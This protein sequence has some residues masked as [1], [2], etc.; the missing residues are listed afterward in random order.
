MSRDGAFWAIFRTANDRNMLRD[1]AALFPLDIYRVVS[2]IAVAGELDHDSDAL[3]AL[4]VASEKLATKYSTDPKRTELAGRLYEQALRLRERTPNDPRPLRVID[5]T[6]EVQTSGEPTGDQRAQL[7]RSINNLADE[8]HREIRQNTSTKKSGTYDVKA[9]YKRAQMLGAGSDDQQ[10][11]EQVAHADL[12][13]AD[14][15]IREKLSEAA[16]KYLKHEL[17]LE[18][19]ITGKSME[20]E[21]KN[22]DKD[23]D[24]FA[25]LG[26]LANGLK[27]AKDRL[28]KIVVDYPDRGA[29]VQ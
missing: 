21:L 22:L 19:K 12:A 15:Y 28:A 24:G 9:L 20:P 27:Q 18:S 3:I 23:G 6:A 26:E 29:S 7:I 1:L 4:Q 11:M 2:S 14:M 17:K 8:H 16:Y 10:V 5:L 25:D 13:L